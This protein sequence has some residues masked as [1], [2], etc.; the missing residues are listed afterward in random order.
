MAALFN[1]LWGFFFFFLVMLNYLVLFS[2]QHSICSRNCWK[3]R[4]IELS[5]IFFP[6]LVGI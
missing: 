1:N 2:C 4:A 6:F 5:I 3:G